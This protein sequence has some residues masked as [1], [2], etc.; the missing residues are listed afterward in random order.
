MPQQQVASGSS[1]IEHEQLRFQVRP[2]Q[3][4]WT[5]TKSDGLLGAI[6]SLQM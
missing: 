6:W 1:P 2:T 3:C 5:L 4:A